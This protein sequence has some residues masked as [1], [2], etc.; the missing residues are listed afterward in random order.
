MKFHNC[1]CTNDRAIWGLV[2]I[3]FNYFVGYSLPSSKEISQSVSKKNEKVPELWI[4]E[5][6]TSEESEE[7]I[8]LILVIIAFTITLIL[9]G[10]LIRI[11]IVVS[12]LNKKPEVVQPASSPKGE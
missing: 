9:W 3:I 11:L 4:D 6:L 2:Q 8:N 12:I 1:Y 5:N 7:R 10:F